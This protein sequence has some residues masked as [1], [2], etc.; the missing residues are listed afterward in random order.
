MNDVISILKDGGSSV[1]AVVI[2]IYFLKYM[3]RRDAAFVAAFKE[4]ANVLK[5]QTE[6]LSQLRIAVSGITGITRDHTK[7]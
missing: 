3:S 1:A 4:F 5:A 7:K 6:V 2:T